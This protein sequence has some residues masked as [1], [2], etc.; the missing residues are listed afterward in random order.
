MRPVVAFGP[1]SA[2]AHFAVELIHDRAPA[3]DARVA[4]ILGRE[5]GPT[6]L[7]LVNGASRIRGRGPRLSWRRVV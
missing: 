4:S 5:L 1:L 2:A 3:N 6:L 7:R